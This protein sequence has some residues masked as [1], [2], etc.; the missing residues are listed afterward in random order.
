MKKPTVF[1]KRPILMQRASKGIR[2]I[3]PS[4]K[5][6]YEFQSFYEQCNGTPG[7]EWKNG[8]TSRKT[9][10]EAYKACLEYDENMADHGSNNNSAFLGYL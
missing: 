9:Q 7:V 8:C 6:V 1:G 4:G 5:V 10:K 3:Y 2:I